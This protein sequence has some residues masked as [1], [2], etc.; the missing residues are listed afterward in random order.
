[1]NPFYKAF[2]LA[3]F[4]FFVFFI[5]PVS[6]NLEPVTINVI[7]VQEDT[8]MADR[9]ILYRL[10]NVDQGYEISTRDLTDGDGRLN[11]DLEPG[12]YEF[13]LG[14]DFED[15]PGFDY[16]GESLVTVRSG[17]AGLTVGV[18]P[19]G[20]LTLNFIDRVGN[21][22]SD[23]SLRVD[24]F[25][26]HGVQDSVESDRFGFVRLDYLPVGQCDFRATSNDFFISYIADVEQGM[27]EN[28]TLR[29]DE[30]R[31]GSGL[32]VLFVVSMV[33]LFVG[34][35]IGLFLLYRFGR[36]LVVFRDGSGESVGK[37][38]GL[39]VGD[40]KGE[41]FEGDDSISDV[42]KG[43]LLGLR[44]REKKLVE[45]LIEKE[46]EAGEDGVRL[47]QAKLV[48]G[49][50]IPKTSLARLVDSLE[51]KNILSVDKVG[52]LKKIGLSEFFNSQ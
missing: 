15:T 51:S 34:V 12:I 49:T 26:G 50:G 19:V 1:M 33:S 13:E 8:S 25:A 9:T 18:Q 27:R 39:G 20:S 38:V 3:F 14:V 16:Y 17:G 45:F 23:V 29:F 36:R 24:C 2:V 11:I 40:S 43:I 47:S 46:R 4:A 42:K 41:G 7:G 21:P 35:S 22:M 31:L 10:V 32:N 44:G 5:I 48:R 28:T 30:L 52:K 37:D 6:A